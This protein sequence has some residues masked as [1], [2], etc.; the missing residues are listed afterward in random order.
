[1]PKTSIDNT[2]ETQAINSP[3]V[4]N[5]SIKIYRNIDKYTF[6]DN[7]SDNDKKEL[8]LEII[9]HILKKYK[10]IKIYELSNLKDYEKE[11]FLNFGYLNNTFFKF[12]KGYFL[13]LEDENISIILNCKEHLTIKIIL[14][15]LFNIDYY[16]ILEGFERYLAKGFQ[17]VATTKYGYL[18]SKIRNCGLALKTS[19]LLHLKGLLLN[20]KID[21]IT[22][23][24]FQRGYIIKSW[25]KLSDNKTNE[26]FIASSRLNFGVTEYQLIE[27]FISGIDKLVEMNQKELF[28]YYSTNKEEINDN[29]YRSYGILKYASQIDYIEAINHISNLRMGLELNLNISMNIETLNKL[30]LEI[31]SGYVKKVAKEQDINENKAR[32]L[33]I[34]NN[35][36]EGAADV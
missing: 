20:N 28:S 4:V 24:Y 23:L 31:Q 33:I 36:L 8:E 3:S 12:S 14:N 13:V 6:A 19:V 34:K 11:L 21:E 17:F 22:S 1:M 29:I 9:D 26:Y 27:R 18:T 35:I 5:S 30:F 7:I 16:K 32:A 25:P 2:L 10:D 15:K